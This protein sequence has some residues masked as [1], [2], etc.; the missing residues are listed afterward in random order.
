MPPTPT[1]GTGSFDHAISI[2]PGENTIV[3]KGDAAQTKE[4]NLEYGPK[5]TVIAHGQLNAEE[6]TI[7]VRYVRQ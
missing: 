4:G 7:W 3:V 1:L 2:V 6:G 5:V